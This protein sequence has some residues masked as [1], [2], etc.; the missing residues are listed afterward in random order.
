MV[1]CQQE[2]VSRGCQSFT[3]IGDKDTCTQ[4]N[5]LMYTVAV[6]ETLLILRSA[7]PMG[8]RLISQSL[9]L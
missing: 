6:A 2:E 1:L 5:T 3:N 7:S 8:A 4:M 9:L